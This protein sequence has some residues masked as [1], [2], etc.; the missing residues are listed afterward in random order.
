MSKPDPEKDEFYKQIGY[1][2]SAW[3]KVEER[4]FEI[5]WKCLQA[6]KEQAA[7]IYFRTPSLDA[8]LTLTDELVKSVLPKPTRKSG[9]H[10]AP[11]V[12]RWNGLESKIRSCLNIRRRIAHNP[13][14]PNEAS[15]QFDDDDQFKGAGFSFSWYELYVSDH[16]EARGRDIKPKNLIVTDLIDHELALTRLAVD[17][18]SF[19]EDVLSKQLPTPSAPSRRKRRG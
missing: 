2:I 5:C 1:C 7:I 4:L 19:C 13:V 17:L 11:S 3:A 14:R 18:K 6:P 15:F 16:E 12:K 8:R 9:G 10:E